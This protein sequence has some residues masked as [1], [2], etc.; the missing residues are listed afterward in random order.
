MKVLVTG[1]A[2]FIGHHLVTALVA[3][4][5]DVVVLD[6]FSSGTHDRVSGITAARIVEGDLREGPE[7]IE[8]LKGREVV[9]HQAAIPSVARSVADPADQPRQC[10]GTIEVMFAARAGVRRVVY[11]GSSS[12]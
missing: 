10:R 6:D 2:G 8:A 1:G 11:A 9:F 7:L 4:G 12:V 5:D 3:R